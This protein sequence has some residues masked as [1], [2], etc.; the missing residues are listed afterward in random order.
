MGNI[1]RLGH[2]FNKVIPPNSRPKT[3]TK[4]EC[5][6]CGSEKP[7]VTT[8]MEIIKEEEVKR[9][10]K[11]CPECENE[12]IDLL[13]MPTIEC[14]KCGIIGL[15]GAVYYTNNKVMC[16]CEYCNEPIK[17]Q[18]ITPS[19]MVISF[20]N[21]DNAVKDIVRGI[22]TRFKDD[23]ALLN[24]LLSSFAIFSTHCKTSDLGYIMDYILNL[25]NNYTDRSMPKLID[26]MNASNRTHNGSNR[27]KFI[28]VFRTL[29][30]DV[31]FEFIDFL[32]NNTP[33]DMEHE[34]MTFFEK[35]RQSSKRKKA[36]KDNS[37]LDT[38]QL[39]SLAKRN[40]A[41]LKKG[42]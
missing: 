16:T 25:R 23:K 33:Q 10:V 38:K 29:Q 17:I 9:V 20:Q 18:D 34:L 11:Q 14:V 6:E 2:P 26:K 8:H 15:L 21:R 24:D 40:Y 1:E 37:E 31:N 42:K 36:N 19:E 12:V 22:N 3:N 39:K 41:W 30:N 32:F 4:K 27:E 7:Y 35:M 13:P 28:R 5:E